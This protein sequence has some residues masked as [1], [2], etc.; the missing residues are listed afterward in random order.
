MTASPDE[1]LRTRFTDRIGCTL[2]IQLAAM[3]GVSTVALAAAVAAEGGL[4]MLA[5]V[6]IGPD[7][8]AGRIH[9]AI[10]LSRPSGRVG[11]G[12]LMPFLDVEAFE[13]AVP[14]VPLLE[15]FYGDPDPALVERAHRGG[16][17]MA[18]QVGSVDEARSAVDAGCDLVV[19]QGV[20]AGGHVRG[21]RPLLPLLGEVRDRVEVPLIAAGGIGTGRQAAAVL[22]AGA[23]AVRIGTRFLATA[24]ADVH[25]AYLDA[26]AD[27]TAGDTEVTEAFSAAWPHAPHR[28]LRSCIGASDDPP[29]IRLPLP[30]TRDFAGDASALYAGTS[31]SAVD[32]PTTVAAAVADLVAGMTAASAETPGA[33]TAAP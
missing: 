28:V 24:E 19:V 30:P 4:G 1:I 21:D 27:A 22:R 25:P 23:D 18:W 6:G 11:V 32:G 17:L 15:C 12:F 3:G 5:G 20:E 14:L 33:T 7:D 29:E 10:D 31:V 13:A 16:A 26:L 9:D 8:L 2:P